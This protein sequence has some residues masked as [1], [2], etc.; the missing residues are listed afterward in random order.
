MK[1][2]SVIAAITGSYAAGKSL[3]A[4]EFRKLGAAVIDADVLAREIVK[5]GSEA[6]SEI[7][8][9]FGIEILNPDGTL[10]RKKLAGIIFADPDSRVKLEEITHPRIRELFLKK[11]KETKETLNPPGLIIYVVPLLFESKNKYPEI[12]KIIVVSAP[13]KESIERIIQRDGSSRELAEK[14]YYSQMPIAEKEKRGDYV[15]RNNA[16][17]TA[18]RASV[19]KVFSE[20]MK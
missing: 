7:T 19:N 20:L 1:K 15:I 9:K 12:E 3:V 14:K 18:L 4:E 16:D 13:E 5:P 11:F 2:S 8:K 6:L 17:M 10:D